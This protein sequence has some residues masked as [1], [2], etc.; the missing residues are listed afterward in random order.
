MNPNNAGE[1]NIH[2]RL[3]AAAI[4]GDRRKL[5]KMLSDDSSLA[6]WADADGLTILMIAAMAGGADT[7]DCLINHGAAVDSRDKTGASALTY[8]IIRAN[9]QAAA[10][11]LKRGANVFQKDKSGL[12]AS[13]L[14]EVYGQKEIAA[15]IAGK[16]SSRGYGVM[17]PEGGNYLYVSDERKNSGLLGSIFSLFITILKYGF[18]M[19][20]FLIAIG[21]YVSKNE[22]ERVSPY[23][24]KQSAKKEP[25]NPQRAKGASRQSKR[26]VLSPMLADYI[27]NS[28]PKGAR[29]LIESGVFDLNAAGADSLT[30]L[31]LASKYG[32]ADLVALLIEKGADLETTDSG[33]GTA[34]FY[35]I[36]GGFTGIVKILLDRGANFEHASSTGIRPLIIAAKKTGG[37]DIVKLLIEKGASVNAETP[38][39]DT[40]LTWAAYSGNYDAAALLLAA[41][42]D[43]GVTTVHGD[44]AASLARKQGF[45][46]IAE[47]IENKGR[48]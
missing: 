8:S 7:V 28:N 46:K 47:L 37:E 29:S 6:N 19:L 41:G 22:G 3:I 4:S 39:R 44:T 24:S 16:S 20:L 36:D 27:K 43:P 35:A 9:V 1:N 34:L 32:Y 10:A 38:Y 40:A 26:K 15:L 33:G 11:L 48:R 17:K 13:E 14:A 31:M 23:P 45:P 21:I 18:V 12:T 42:A 25:A 5:E 2:D 30:P